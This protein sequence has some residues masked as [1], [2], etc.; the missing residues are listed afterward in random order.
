MSETAEEKILVT[1]GTGFL[2]RAVLDKLIA[3]NERLFVLSRNQGK[4]FLARYGEKIH[5]AT[6]D[7][8]DEA[9]LE[10]IFAEIRPDKIIHLAGC[11]SKGNKAE[12]LESINYTAT[13]KIL[14]IARAI[15]VKR[16][17]LT[18]TADEYGFQA[19]PQK[20]TFKAMPVSDYAISKN[21]AVIYALA[22]HR[23]EDQTLQV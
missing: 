12:I 15:R 9:A 19:A 23:T 13:I 5:P 21:K 1:G 16:I 6:A 10:K 2:G 8:L 20:E 14:E 4:E 7:L 11:A 17:V 22:L 3:Q 18:G